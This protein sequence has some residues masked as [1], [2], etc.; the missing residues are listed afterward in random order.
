VVYREEGEIRL[1][2]DLDVEIMGE[3]ESDMDI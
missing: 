2:S 1:D 3:K